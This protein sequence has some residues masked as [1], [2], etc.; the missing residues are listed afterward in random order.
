MLP[1]AH[2]VRK[3]LAS[4]WA[5]YWYAYRGGPQI[6][7]AFG[8]TLADAEA[9]ERAQAGDIARLYSESRKPAVMRGFISGLIADYKASDSWLGMRESTRNLWAP[10]LDE[11]DKVFGGTSLKAIQQ[12]GARRIIRDWHYGMA[13]QPRKA[14]TAL[15]VL[16]RLFQHGLDMEDMDKNPAAGLPK[17]HEGDGRA[18]IVWSPEALDAVLGL[19]RPAMA[20]SIR[21]AYLTG[22][23]R[24]D[25][26]K[27]RW[28]EIDG[29]FIVRPTLKSNG[30][31]IA[32]IPVTGELKDLLAEMPRNG[33]QVVT[34]ERGKPYKD[35]DAHASTFSRLRNLADVKPLRFHDLRGTRATL[36]FAS[37]MPDRDIEMFM[38]WAPGSA[39]RM[40]D[41]YGSP[42]LMAEAMARRAG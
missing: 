1:G 7:A 37:S 17:L 4:G 26:V 6:G 27:L 12:R 11:I 40:R 13:E 16:V 29:A 30:H 28:N 23:R 14:N 8:E 3:K 9:D 21:L 36:L 33:V 25:L 38:G 18:A 19:A 22:L 35:G 31:R 39:P 15:T 20:R 10:H 42:Q 5:I 24:E 32:R 2:R 34:G 41:I